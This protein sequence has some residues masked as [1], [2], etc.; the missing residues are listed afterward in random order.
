MIFAASG[1]EKTTLRGIRTGGKGD[2][3]QT[4]IAWEQKKGVPSQSSLLHVKPYIYAV[5]DGGIATCYGADTGEVVWQERL[6]GNHSA[7]PIHANGQVYFLSEQG[8]SVVIQGGE[9]FK[10]IA[11]N[12]VGEKCQA[13][14]AASQGN[15][16][17]RSEK[18]LFCIG[19]TGQGR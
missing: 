2:V 16:F 11:R 8:E 9:Q 4:H 17:I 10:E 5:T 18:N 14:Y 13:S 6:G 12:S 7:S 19:A 3:T 1:F 15:L